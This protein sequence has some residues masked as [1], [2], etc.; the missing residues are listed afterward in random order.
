MV[1]KMATFAVLQA[2]A[3][4][5]VLLWVQTQKKAARPGPDKQ[6]KFNHHQMMGFDPVF[7]VLSV[8]PTKKITEKVSNPSSPTNISYLA[9]I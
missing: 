2:A 8:S 9:D 7:W 1:A 6:Q 4:K 5:A 3:G